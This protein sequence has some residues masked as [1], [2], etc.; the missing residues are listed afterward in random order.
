[1]SGFYPLSRAEADALNA[2]GGHEPFTMETYQPG[3]KR[4]DE[5]ATYRLF[6]DQDIYALNPPGCETEEDEQ[7]LKG[8]KYAVYDARA[9]WKWVKHHPN[10]PTNSFKI[11]F[12]SWCELRREYESTLHANDP[13][14]LDLVPDFVDE[15]PRTGWID[16]GP[17]IK[18]VK[19]EPW[20]HRYCKRQV[21]DGYCWVALRNDGEI[22]FRTFNRANGDTQWRPCDGYFLCGQEGSECIHKI[23]YK[24]WT[25][26][27]I[28]DRG[29]EV[30]YM[31][32]TERGWMLDYARVNDD[33]DDDEK[34]ALMRVRTRR[35]KR[36]PAY[37]WPDAARGRL[38]SARSP[39]GNVKKF[40]TGP[41][42]YE[43]TWK[44]YVWTEHD[45]DTEVFFTGKRGKERVYRIN[46]LDIGDVLHKRG[47]ANKE[48]I[49]KREILSTNVTVFYQ[50]GR[51][52]E[53]IRCIVRG[54]KTIPAECVT[55][56]FSGPRGEERADENRAA[57]IY[58]APMA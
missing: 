9:L 37:C 5:G 58:A 27:Y 12:E 20:T 29:R 17:D 10:D 55:T 18:W 56:F 26:Y 40:Y 6:W 43:R 4:G 51:N 30:C 44:W 45:G 2:N 42:G 48:Y 1:M 36:A 8:R 7:L 23:V 28:G 57:Q 52:A 38:I 3:R 39:D 47:S 15:L 16:F 32:R 34:N 14:A 49:W 24:G 11:S 53:A 46:R 21:D 50:G 19:R 54:S 35:S 22:F 31:A 13:D 25:D 41:K 33:G